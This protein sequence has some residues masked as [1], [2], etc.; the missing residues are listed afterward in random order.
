MGI[1]IERS[2]AS[3]KRHINAYAEGKTDEDHLAAIA[4]NIMFMIHTEEMCER[5][6]LPKELE[7]KPN[8]ISPTK[9]KTSKKKRI[10]QISETILFRSIIL[11]HNFKNTTSLTTTQNERVINNIIAV[12]ASPYMDSI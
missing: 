6:M 2:L 4:C 5:G 9:K 8:Y 7:F 3:L 12:G 1:P 10:K 11:I